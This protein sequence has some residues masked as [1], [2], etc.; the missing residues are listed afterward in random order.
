MGR[1]LCLMLEL[2]TCEL[3]CILPMNAPADSKSK[4]RMALQVGAVFIF[5][6]RD[7]VMSVKRCYEVQFKDSCCASQAT[8]CTAPFLHSYSP[9]ILDGGTAFVVQFLT[10]SD[11]IIHRSTLASPS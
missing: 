11:V 8:N 9:V 3:V 4:E 2:W 6:D 7:G 5:V 1:I 10:K